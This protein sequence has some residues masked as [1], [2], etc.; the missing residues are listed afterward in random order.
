M[1]LAAPSKELLTSASLAPTRVPEPVGAIGIP[2]PLYAERVALTMRT[3]AIY[4]WLQV[5]LKLSEDEDAYIIKNLWP[6]SRHDISE[7]HG[8]VPNRHGLFGVDV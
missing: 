5:E 3:L 7:F 4:A 6:L 8:S 1:I 2:S